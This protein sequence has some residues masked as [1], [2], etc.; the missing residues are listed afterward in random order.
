MALNRKRFRGRTTR[1]KRVLRRRIN[2]RRTLA[3]KN[4]THSFVRRQYLTTLQA[5]W[6]TNTYGAFTFK[7]SDLPNYSEFTELF[8]RYRINKVSVMFIPQWTGVD[9]NPMT[10]MLNNNPE[11]WTM[12][13]YNDATTPVSLDEFYEDNHSKITRG[14][15]IHKRYFSPAIRSIAY[16]DDDDNFGYVSKWRQFIDTA[17]PEVP[18]YALKYCLAPT[19]SANTEPMFVKVF[20]KFYFQCKDLK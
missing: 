3:R 6:G 7:L 20:T 19:A 9:A 16:H 18:H 13:D 8:D 10:T 11:I 15:T 5:D 4:P 12:I 14:G 1:R 2:R 17:N